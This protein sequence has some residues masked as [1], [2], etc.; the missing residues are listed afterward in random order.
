MQTLLGAQL[1]SDLTLARIRTLNQGYTPSLPPNDQN[2]QSVLRGVRPWIYRATAL[3]VSAVAYQGRFNL[4]LVVGFNTN[5]AIRYV[6]LFDQPAVPTIGQ[7]PIQSIPVNPEQEFSWSPSQDGLI[8]ERAC[9][10]AIS[11]TAVTF[12][13]SAANLYARIEGLVL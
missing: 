1:L 12:T 13:A 4:N 7:V 8:F 5:A 10:I 3:V 2:N 6:Q 9:V 11:T